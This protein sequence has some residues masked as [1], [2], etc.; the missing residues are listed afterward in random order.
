MKKIEGESD[1]PLAQ[2]PSDVALEK[3]VVPPPPP[4]PVVNKANDVDDG[5]AL[6]PVDSKR[7]LSLSF[8]INSNIFSV[9]KFCL[10]AE[11]IREEK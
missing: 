7:A 3:A 4:P 6:A 8:C 9:I 5:K 1:A 2:P 10:A 11:K